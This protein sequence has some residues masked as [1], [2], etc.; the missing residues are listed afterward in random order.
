MGSILRP[1][2]EDPANT[3]L[4][5]QAGRA[6]SPPYAGW[7]LAMCSF[8]QIRRSHLEPP[9]LSYPHHALLLQEQI[10]PHGDASI[11]APHPCPLP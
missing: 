11:R 8:G 2:K 10:L 7:V 6:V 4:Q 1:R 9:S 3:F 5:D